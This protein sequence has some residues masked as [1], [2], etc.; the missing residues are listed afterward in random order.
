VD[1]AHI[2]NNFE[3]FQKIAQ[4]FCNLGKNIISEMQQNFVELIQ[5]QE[6]NLRESGSAIVG[7]NFPRQ[8]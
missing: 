5:E 3:A 2:S 4:T 7:A 8:F 6:M 1:V